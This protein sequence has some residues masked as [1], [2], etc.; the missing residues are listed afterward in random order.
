[1]INKTRRPGDGAHTDHL[2]ALAA[3]EVGRPQASQ[4]RAGVF[5]MHKHKSSD[6]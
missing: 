6:A 4:T 3:Q 2:G 1:L 5:R